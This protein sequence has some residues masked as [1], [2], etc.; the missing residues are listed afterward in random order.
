MRALVVEV[1]IHAHNNSDGYY[2]QCMFPLVQVIVMSK[3]G[4]FISTSNFHEHKRNFNK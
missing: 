2:M 1:H 3:K 4:I